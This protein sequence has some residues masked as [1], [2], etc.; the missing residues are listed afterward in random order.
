MGIDRSKRITFEEKA[1]QY[2]QDRY[3][4]ALIEAIV[5]RS[6]IP[7]E[8]RI[9]EV[10][11]GPGNATISFAQRGY[12]LL[13]IELGARLAVLAAENCRA[14]PKVQI[15][16]LAFEAW[17]EETAAFDL[18]IAADALHWI[19]PEISYPKAARILKKGGWAAFFWTIPVDPQT[20]W[21][22][23]IDA[24]YEQTTPAFINPNRLF[25][26]EWH[27]EIIRDNFE[28]SQCFGPVSSQQF[29]WIS[30]QTTEQFLNGLRTTSIHHGI[31]EAVREELYA[32]IGNVIE[33]Q[34]GMV[35]KPETAVLYM[36]QVKEL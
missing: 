8:G 35:E 20:G 22:Q 2:T 15:V 24:L 23:E 11:C 14:F 9:L 27:K 30:P 32:K 28:A 31:D 10:G 36:A 34:G 1:D 25:T 4:E 6:G 21:S 5:N 17:A 18:I 7:P 33:K 13:G 12:H 29:E 16:N 26:A 3:P 19:P